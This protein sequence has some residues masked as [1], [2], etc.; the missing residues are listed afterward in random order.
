MK[1]I[2]SSDQPNLGFQ[3]APMIDVVF[4]IMLFFM[5]M[6]G[7]MK[8]E[9]TLPGRLPGVPV[10]AKIKS[11]DLEILLG[12]GEDGTI[13]L[14]DEP[15][16]NPT[17]KTL[18]ALTT[19]LQRLKAAADQQ[20]DKVLVTIQAEQE[21]RYERIVDALNALAKAQISN[22]TFTTVE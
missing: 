3:I 1:I 7:A 11:P 21:A 8:T 6:A 5:L 19:T 22:V 2:T 12:V 10:D 18:P 17:S 16:D 9:A 13:T 14:N 15:F 4:V 20:K